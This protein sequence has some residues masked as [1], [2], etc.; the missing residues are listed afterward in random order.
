[1]CR[2]EEGELNGKQADGSVRAKAEGWTSLYLKSIQDACRSVPDGYNSRLGQSEVNKHNSGNISATT[3]TDYINVASEVLAWLIATEDDGGPLRSLP[4][5]PTDT[6]GR[7]MTSH[8]FVIH[9]AFLRLS[10]DDR[11]GCS[12]N[13]MSEMLQCL[14]LQWEKSK[15]SF[16]PLSA[17]DIGKYGTRLIYLFKQV[18]R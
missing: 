17:A 3:L 13:H 14:F 2:K 16:E 7:Q 10:V 5:H 9:D 8:L 15:R 6:R 12:G 11:V 1:M 18:W 4:D